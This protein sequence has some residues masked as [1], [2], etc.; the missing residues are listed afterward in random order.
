[1]DGLEQSDRPRGSVN[2]SKRMEER[3]G[4]SSCWPSNIPI[5]HFNSSSHSLQSFHFISV[6]I[7][8]TTNTTPAGRKRKHPSP[9]HSPFAFAAAI[10][11]LSHFKTLLTFFSQRPDPSPFSSNSGR[12]FDL[13]PSLSQKARRTAA[14]L[15]WTILLCCC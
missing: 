13:L 11:R 7:I 5:L 3:L 15:L 6:D 8:T 9:S 4:G 1:M 10:I 14:L 2:C 12:H